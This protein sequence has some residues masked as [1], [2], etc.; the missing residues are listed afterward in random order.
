MACD[1]GGEG[2]RNQKYEKLVPIIS[3]RMSKDARMMNTRL[4]LF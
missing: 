4:L 2:T 3:A 1:T